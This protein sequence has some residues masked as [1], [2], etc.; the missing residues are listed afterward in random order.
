MHLISEIGSVRAIFGL[1]S[2]PSM[3]MFE[4]Q[5]KF[6]EQRQ[7]SNDYL[8]LVADKTGEAVDDRIKAT[9]YELIPTR[10]RT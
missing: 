6:Q 7:E 4:A 3:Q 9:E 5:H 10:S 8:A 1:M 2:V